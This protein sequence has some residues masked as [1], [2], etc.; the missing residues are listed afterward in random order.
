METD[1][2]G[3]SVSDRICTVRFADSGN[4][5]HSLNKDQEGTLA[6]LYAL[7]E[8]TQESGESLIA[9]GYLDVATG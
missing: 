8:V 1:P 7:L 4:L 5:P 6:D 3:G 2:H 9:V